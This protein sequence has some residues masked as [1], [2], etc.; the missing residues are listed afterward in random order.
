MNSYNVLDLQEGHK[1]LLT[2]YIQFFKIKKEKFVRDIKLDIEDFS[3][4]KYH[5]I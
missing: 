1:A 2:K 5:F 3:S 4:K